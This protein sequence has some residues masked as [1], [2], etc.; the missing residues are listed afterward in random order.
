MN[1]QRILNVSKSSVSL[2]KQMQQQQGNQTF[3]F[4]FDC[5]II[6]IVLKYR[7][8]AALFS[9]AQTASKRSH[10]TVIFIF[11]GDG[12]GMGRNILSFLTSVIYPLQII[13]KLLFDISKIFSQAILQKPDMEVTY[14]KHWLNVNLCPLWKLSLKQI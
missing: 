13:S 10:V 7:Q 12:T 1:Q 11:V 6:R 3:I 4:H 5:I 14:R 9:D 8:S 2:I